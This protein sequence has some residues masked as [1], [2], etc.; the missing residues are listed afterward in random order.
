MG[1]EGFSVVNMI[2]LL[3]LLPSHVAYAII[4]I[5]V[6][7]VVAALGA[8]GIRKGGKR[9]YLAEGRLTFRTAGE[10]IV[11]SLLKLV[12]E[13]MGPRGPEF[14]LIIGTLA[15]FILLSNILGMIPGFQS[16]TSNINTT[17]ACAV[18]VFVLTHYYGFREHGIKYLKQFIGP[19]L[20][21][22]PLMIIIELIGHCVRPVSLSIRLFGN[23]F[24]DH[25]ATAVFFFLVPW[26]LPL[27][28]M[29]LGVLVAIIQTFV[30]ILLSMSY[31][32][33]AIEGHEH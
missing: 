33:L 10:V 23:I 5:V 11:E 18:T 17:A 30:F 20:A 8:R 24:G 22:A 19:L 9:S 15:L 4:V 1:H 12:K 3:N 32:S 26:L 21:L 27:P 31:F 6:L 29:F 7:M 2:P 25:T 14:M 28:M 16:P 13:Q